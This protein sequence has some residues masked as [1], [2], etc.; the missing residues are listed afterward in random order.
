MRL[1]VAKR[2][3]ATVESDGAFRICALIPAKDERLGIGKTVRSILAAGLAPQDVYVID[4][5][6]RDDTRMIA[7]SFGANVLR[8]ENNI[9]KAHSI[10][11]GAEYFQLIDRYDAIALMD[12]DTEVS[13]GYYE[14]VKQS[15]RD[16]QVGA[17]C[18][19][20]KSLRYNWLTAYRCL[21]Y[22][23]CHFV[24]RAGQNAMRVI[25][26]AP[27]C[28][29]TFRTGVFKELEWC[30][31]TIVEDMDCTIQVHKRSLGRIVYQDKA[32]VYTQ[33]P[34]SVRDYMKQTYRWYA[35]AWQVG[36]K[37]KMLRSFSKIDREY[38]LL[39]AEGLIFALVIT[40]TPLWM[41]LYPQKYLVF[42]FVNAMSLAF[43]AVLAG[44][45]AGRLDVV[46]FSPLYVFMQGLDCL[47][48]LY[49]FWK[50]VLRDQQLTTWM[51]VKR[52]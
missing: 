37:H 26:V 48:F 46:L 40:F 42:A 36:R 25:T 49:S 14:F 30:R 44:L 43:I 16:I 51:A 21:S 22:F 39:M 7:L 2:K 50:A 5:G 20:P 10:R 31:D 41:L 9:G 13:P 17:V 4:D 33:D 19:R 18:G 6:S 45:E 47:V 38:Q 23:M 27:G 35:G 52:Y 11:R 24:Y 15:F 29:T 1:K 34:K 28:S 12:A 32:V 8:N 3:P